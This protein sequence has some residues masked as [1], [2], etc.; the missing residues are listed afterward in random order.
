MKKKELKT[1]R[2]QYIDFE[3]DVYS[4]GLA[5]AV[6]FDEKDDIKEYGVKW[7]ADKKQWWLPAAKVNVD[8]VSELNSR[9]MIVGQ[10]GAIDTD[11]AE[12]I[13]MDLESTDFTLKNM[14]GDTMLF[15]F[16]EGPALV[17][18]VDGQTQMTH[19]DNIETARKRWNILVDQG[20]FVR[21]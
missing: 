14:E 8:T 17:R 19:W 20:G 11:A 16:Y 15:N 10:Y 4:E 21:V 7:D 13:C 9:K 1:F 2:D 3:G 12:S 5:L 6:H 18:V